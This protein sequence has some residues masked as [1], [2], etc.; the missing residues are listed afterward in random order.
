VC[1]HPNNG[2]SNRL[3]CLRRCVQG[4]GHE[5]DC[6][7]MFHHFPAQS[8]AETT[9]NTTTT[10]VNHK[11]STTEQPT[12]NMSRC[13]FNVPNSRDPVPTVSVAISNSEL[14]SCT[15]HN[16]SPS[17]SGRKASHTCFLDVEWT[18]ILLCTDKDSFMSRCNPYGPQCNIVEITEEDDF[19]MHSG[20]GY[21]KV[22]DALRQPNCVVFASLPCTGGSPWQIVNKRHPACRRLLRK[23]Y[24]LF[25]QLFDSLLKLYDELR[26]FGPIPII[27]EWPRCC[28]YW[29]IPKVER[30]LRKWKL[31]TAKFDGCA[32][33]LRSCIEREK[34]KYLK[35]PW[36]VAT[37]IP[38][39][40]HALDGRLCPGTSLDHVHGVTCGR[41]AKHS[42]Y[43]TAELAL[44]YTTL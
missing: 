17:P 8:S 27:F 30:F 29:K 5:G 20:E 3:F 28:R 37:N 16:F 33:G 9:D 13:S 19:R 23:H 26:G 34:E 44:C 36:L 31:T 41:N 21:D 7:C 40:Q 35:K 24:T 32:F 6:A 39:V 38:A 43:Y 11:E 25:N 18:I 15:N 14:S 42:Q 12:T 1:L 10:T 4:V 22:L 2:P